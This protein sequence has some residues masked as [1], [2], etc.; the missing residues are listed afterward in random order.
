M[1]K[2]YETVNARNSAVAAIELLYADVA[3]TLIGDLGLD[4]KIGQ[5]VEQEDERKIL[6]LI[7]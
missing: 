2:S 3:I 7:A 6:A 1:T 4:V 5:Y